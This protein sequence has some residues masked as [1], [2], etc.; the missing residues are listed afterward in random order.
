M[1]A[2]ISLTRSRS[3]IALAELRFVP[4]QRR[5]GEAGLGEAAAPNLGQLLFETRPLDPTTYA[6]ASVFLLAVTLLACALPAWRASRVSLVGA[7][8]NE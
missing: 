7:L 1:L 4:G 3:L 5:I 2:K 6:I 8:R